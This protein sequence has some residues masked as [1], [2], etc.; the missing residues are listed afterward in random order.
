[1]TN[2]LEKSVIPSFESH[3]MAKRPPNPPPTGTMSSAAP[4]E[5]I[6]M[7]FARRLQAALNE[8]GWT[9]SELARRMVPLLKHSRLGRDNISKYVRG[10]VLPLPPALEAMAKVLEMKTSELL[11]AR[12]TPPA[13]AEYAPMSVKDIGDGR[14]WLQINR[15]VTWRKGLEILRILQEEDKTEGS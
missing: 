12:A 11:P 13:G 5:A 8:R 14:V 10:K 3:N 15:S 7:E 9:Q 6:R 4:P 2:D 1:M